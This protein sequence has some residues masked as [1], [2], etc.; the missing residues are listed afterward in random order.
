MIVRRQL[1]SAGAI[2]TLAAGILLASAAAGQVRQAPRQDEC[3]ELTG[4]QRTECEQRVSDEDKAHKRDDSERQPEDPG[5]TDQAHASPGKDSAHRNPSSRAESAA[6]RSQADRSEDSLEASRA[7]SA[8][9]Q[10]SSSQPHAAPS[11][12]DEPPPDTTS[13]GND[14]SDTA[15]P[16]QE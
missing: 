2:G 12:A 7:R 10:S 1:L 9:E 6:P 11:D 3:Q 4:V 5:P 15:D 8:D 13:D 16:P 14:H